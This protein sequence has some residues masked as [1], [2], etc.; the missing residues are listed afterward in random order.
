MPELGVG[1][2]QN[3]NPSLFRSTRDA[4]LF[5]GQY[6]GTTGTRGLIRL[7]WVRNVD[8]ALAKSF[9][10]PW[11]GHALQVRGEAFNAFNFVNFTGLQTNI[12]NATFGQFSG[13]SEARVM[14]FAL[15]YEF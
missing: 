15:R 10:M 5:M 14:Q 9:R 11:E 4:D 13:A 6:A 12:N 3:G 1:F 2:N 7:P 8:L